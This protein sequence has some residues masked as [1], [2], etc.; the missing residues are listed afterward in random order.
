MFRFFI[1]LLV[2]LGPAGFRRFL[3]DIAPSP[4]LRKVKSVVDVMEGTSMEIFEQKVSAL[5]QGDEMILRQV[6]EGKDVMSILCQ[7]ICLCVRRYLSLY[8]IVKANQSASSADRLPDNELIAQMR[9]LSL[10]RLSPELIFIYH[11]VHSCSQVMTL[12]LA[13]YRMFFIVSLNIQR[14]NRRSGMN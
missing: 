3:L 10:Q 9:C 11:A 14:S 13:L 5:K 4:D 6:G 7:C 12:P 2:K 1:P 8:H